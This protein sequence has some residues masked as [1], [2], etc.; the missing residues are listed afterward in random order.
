MLLLF[1]D[2]KF[3]ASCKPRVAY[4]SNNMVDCTQLVFDDSFSRIKNEASFL[5]FGGLFSKTKTRFRFRGPDWMDKV[6]SKTKTRFCSSFSR[7]RLDRPD[8]R[9]TFKSP[10]NLITEKVL[11]VRS[12]EVIR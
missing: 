12:S 2:G 3:T 6:S 9:R 1:S 7:Y 10:L 8:E 11:A 4:L 5:I